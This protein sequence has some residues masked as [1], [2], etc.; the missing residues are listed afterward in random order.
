[1]V[2]HVAEAFKLRLQGIVASVLLL[3]ALFDFGK[4]VG[5]GFQCRDAGFLLG[6][7]L[8][9]QRRQTAVGLLVVVVQFLADNDRAPSHR[10]VVVAQGSKFFGDHAGQEIRVLQ[11]AVIALAEQIAK[12]RPACGLVSF[13]ADETGTLVLR[14]DCRFGQLV[15]D[16]MRV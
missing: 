4:R 8:N 2:G 10:E 3:G 16:A 1:M 5:F 11:I 14:L 12:H 15:L 9:Q 13:K 6:S 7:E